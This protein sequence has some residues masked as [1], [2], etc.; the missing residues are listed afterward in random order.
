[1]SA[2]TCKHNDHEVNCTC[3]HNA[4]KWQGMEM[5]KRLILGSVLKWYEVIYY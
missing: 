1:M 2:L 3:K 4:N 5:C